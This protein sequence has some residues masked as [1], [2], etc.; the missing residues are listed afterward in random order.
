MQ[1]EGFVDSLGN[2]IGLSIVCSNILAL[3]MHF[4]RF[5]DSLGQYNRFLDRFVHLNLS[6]VLG[7][8]I[9]LS[10]VYYHNL[11]S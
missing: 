5:V 7:V 10:I 4:Y 9:D 2:I 11:Y 3:W 1:Y 8:I 6:I